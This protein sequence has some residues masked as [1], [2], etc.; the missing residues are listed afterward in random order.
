MGFDWDSFDA[1]Q[2][3]VASWPPDE[4]VEDGRARTEWLL[5]ML[6]D[7]SSEG[8][9]ALSTQ[10][11]SQLASGMSFEVGVLGPRTLAVTSFCAADMPGP[12]RLGAA[13]R[14]WT[15]IDEHVSRIS[16]IGE[17]HRVVF[18]EFM[19]QRRQ[20]VESIPGPARN[21]WLWL[22]LIR[23]EPLLAALRGKQSRS[24]RLLSALRESDH[25]AKLADYFAHV[26]PPA[27]GAGEKLP[28]G[29]GHEIR[30]LMDMAIEFGIR[31]TRGGSVDS[32]AYS[33]ERAFDALC[34]LDRIAGSGAGG[35]FSTQE[36]IAWF[37]DAVQLAESGIVTSVMNDRSLEFCVQ[38][39]EVC[40][41]KDVSAA[42]R[43]EE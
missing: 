18:P 24:D 39:A 28:F 27:R 33:T 42:L 2:I 4:V 5:H 1:V 25:D 36:D 31:G 32:M 15:F 26:L 34:V 20:L 12:V 38:L 7:V 6:R 16:M 14:F 19:R 3:G 23:S 41:R 22:A 40:S 11:L 37:D 8:L 10:D 21:A 13:A 30:R 43:G 35:E 9:R 29:Q 17:Q